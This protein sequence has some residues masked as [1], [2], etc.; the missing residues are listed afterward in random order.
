MHLLYTKK[1][2]KYTKHLYMYILKEKKI[3]IGK[4]YIENVKTVMIATLK[5]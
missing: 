4:N 2:I 3:Y 1:Y 5:Y